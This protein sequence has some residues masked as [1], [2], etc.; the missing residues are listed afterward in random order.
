MILR[1]LIELRNT[2]LNA[3]ATAKKWYWQFCV[4]YLR[5]VGCSFLR[6]WSR[7]KETKTQIA[8]FTIFLPHNFVAFLVVQE[9][10]VYELYKRIQWLTHVLDLWGYI[11]DSGLYLSKYNDHVTIIESDPVNFSYLTKNLQQVH[12]VTAHNKAVVAHDNEKFF[13]VQDN[14]Y[15]WTVSNAASDQHTSIEIPTISIQ[16]LLAEN[17]FDWLKMDIEWGEYPLITYFIEHN[18]FPFK[19]WFIEFHFTPEGFS[20]Q[21]EL[22]VQFIGFLSTKKFL[23]EIFD[24][25]GKIQPTIAFF[26][27]LTTNTLKESYINLYFQAL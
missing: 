26:E 6:I 16:K 13:L 23:Y 17:N 12:N 18:L 20:S 27:Q 14:A 9:I 7:E 8:G 24:N 19:K 21:K 5:V 25:A 1:Y 4:D 11:G 22:F 15:R 2:L 3:V 10:F